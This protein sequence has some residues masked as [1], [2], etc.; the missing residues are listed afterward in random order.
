MDGRNSAASQDGPPPTP[1]ED[2]SA[3]AK[4][5][6]RDQLG[7]ARHRIPLAVVAERSAEIAEHVLAAPEV[8]RAASVAA[9]VSIGHEPGTGL[10]IERLHAAGKRVL[11]PIVLPDL[12][13]DWAWYAGPD[14]LVRARMGLL[15]PS[16]PR[17]GVEAIGTP[18]AV[19]VPGVAVDRH[20]MRMGRGGGCYDRALGRVPVG[21][22]VC[23][24]LYASEVLAEVPHT[25]HDRPVTAV[26]T[27]IG[28][29]RF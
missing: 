10:L 28:I 12:D 16:G 19:L 21:T 5:A 29:T 23:A 3:G 15:E 2:P 24:L 13:L 14:S 27:E 1:A 22:F 8:R 20:G 11:L 26:A 7:T 25:D 6:L 9:Y 4:M 17:R 18:D